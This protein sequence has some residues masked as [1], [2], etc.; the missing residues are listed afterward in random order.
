MIPNYPKLADLTAQLVAAKAAESQAA[1]ARLAV[2]RDILAHPDVESALPD[3]GTTTVGALKITTRL[4]RKWDQAVL[5]ELRREVQ[6]DHY[7]PFK[8]EYREDRR[9]T[10][11]IED[12]APELWQRLRDALTTKPAKPSVSIVEEK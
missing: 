2:E 3:E 9:H 7:W 5:A 8:Q 10:R 1:A 6:N 11:V 12:T 4:T